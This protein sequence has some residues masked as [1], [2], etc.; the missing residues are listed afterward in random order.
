MPISGGIKMLMG[1][2]GAEPPL[3]PIAVLGD[4]VI[5]ELN[6]T[7]VATGASPSTSLT[8]FPIEDYL[9]TQVQLPLYPFVTEHFSFTDDVPVVTVSDDVTVDT[10]LVLDIVI[11][12]P[13]AD[14]LDAM[15]TVTDD[16]TNV[17]LI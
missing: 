6:A 3:P 14:V 2:G 9:S 4:S 11:D 10:P 12:D 1:A 15:V 5:V 7:V 16:V 17:Q 8:F 13:V